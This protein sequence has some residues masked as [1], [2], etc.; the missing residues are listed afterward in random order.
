MAV[1]TADG[2]LTYAQ[3]NAQVNRV[4]HHLRRH[5]AG[6]E[7]VVGLCAERSIELVVGM[8]GILKAGAAYLPMDPRDPGR[9]LDRLIRDTG[10][11][12]VLAQPAW[13]HVVPERAGTVITLA[14]GSFDGEPTTD[15]DRGPDTDNLACVLYT[16]GSTGL[17]KGI[18]LP[19]RAIV[20]TLVEQRDIALD[21]ADTVLHLS[22]FNWDA[23]IFE[24]FGPLLTGGTC[25]VYSAEPI[26]PAGIVAAIRRHGV[27]TA[28][29]TTTL[30][31]LVVEEGLE[32][33]GGLRQIFFGGE[34]ASPTHV[35][36]LRTRW[37]DM[38]IANGY[39]PV[40]C[41]FVAT[42]HPVRTVPADAV[43]VPIGRPLDRTTV[44]VLDDELHPVPAG[45]AGELCLGGDSLARGYAGQ[46][47]LTADRFVP[48][49]RGGGRRLYRTG[50]RG[51]WRA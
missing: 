42:T 23:A 43:S 13:R 7:A 16:S 33:L 49:P 37:S 17:P 32:E 34:A 4:A 19:Q 30:F 31:N 15:P 28:F 12:L 11:D 51:R 9:R 8:L 18:A 24:I 27:T 3:L 50:D 36:E 20:D 46:A 1:A 41:T 39:G 38:R 48:D 25:A 22:S 21:T 44:L 47:G 10:A 45:V 2:E 35:R 5:G 29:L 26:T 6:P 14:G 40:E